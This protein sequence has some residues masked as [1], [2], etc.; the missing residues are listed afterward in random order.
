MC[1]VKY[2]I[3]E[4]P[5]E[6]GFSLDSFIDLI[7]SPAALVGSQCTE[8]FI[9]I[10]GSD[11]ECAFTRTTHRYCGSRLN[12]ISGATV[13]W[14]NNDICDCTPPFM[15]T[16]VTDNTAD[17]NNNPILGRGVCLKYTQVPCGMI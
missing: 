17:N 10:E 3:C 8:D 13:S 4:E 1:C 2:S 14:T 9:I 7:G 6:D 11:S 15:V 12:T 16:F 5:N